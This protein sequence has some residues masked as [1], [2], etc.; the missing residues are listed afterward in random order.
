MLKVLGAMLVV[1]WPWVIWGIDITWFGLF[2]ERFTAIPWKEDRGVIL[3]IGYPILLI[4]AL[5]IFMAL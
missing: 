3:L 2:G 1:G 4:V 5:S